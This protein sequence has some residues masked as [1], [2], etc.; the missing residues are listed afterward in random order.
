MTVDGITDLAAAGGANA[1]DR[2]ARAAQAGRQFEGLFLKQL[3]SQL[4]ESAGGEDGLFGSAPGA[5]VMEDWFDDYF[6]AHLAQGR[7]VGLGKQLAGKLAGT[8]RGEPS[9]A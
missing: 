5:G 4:R 2:A 1:A 9:H 3:V 6:A 7:G 8:S